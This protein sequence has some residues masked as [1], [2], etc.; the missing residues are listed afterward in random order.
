MRSK[1]AHIVVVFFII[2]TSF[3]GGVVETHPIIKIVHQ[4]GSALLVVTWLASLWLRKQPFAV[5]RMDWP[6]WGLLGGWIIAAAFGQDPRVSFEFVWATFIHII[7][8]FIAVDVIRSGH[9]RWLFEGLFLT[10]GVIVIL[11]AAE[12]LMWY[13]GIPLVGSGQGWPE[14]GGY[15]IPPVIHELSIPLNHNNPTGAYTVL[16]IPIA[17]AWS[18]TTTETDLKWGLRA[19]AA[20]LL[21]VVVF[22]QSRG[23]YLAFAALIGFSALIWI[24]R[25]DVRA[26]FPR[27]MQ[28][29]IAPRVLLTVTALIGVVAVL[30]LY[31]IIIN[32]RHP[33]VNDVTRIDLWYSAIQIF[34]DYP[35]TGAGPFQ[36]KGFRLFYGNW[37]H[38]Q[39]YLTL[40]HAHNIFFNILAE[41][42]TLLIAL[43]AW[44]IVRAGRVWRASWTRSPQATKRRLEGILV[45]VLAFS[46]HNMVDAFLQTQFV[47]PMVIFLAYVTSTDPLIAPAPSFRSN[48]YSRSKVLLGLTCILVVSGQI[49]YLPILRGALKQQRVLSLVDQ[50][51]YTE[52]L[53]TVRQAQDADP[54]LDLYVLEEATILGH[55]A[56]ESPD[57][58]LD[59][60]I[61]AYET[62][63]VLNE[64]W[65][66]G[67]HNLAALYADAGEYEHAIDAEQNAYQMYPAPTGFQFRLGQYYQLAGD[68]SA[69]RTVYLNLLKDHPWIASSGYWRDPAHPK[70]ASFLDAAI[71]Y[72]AGTISYIDLLVYTGMITSTTQRSELDFPEYLSPDIQEQLDILWPNGARTPC[73]YC[74]HVQ[75]NDLLLEAETLYHTEQ[76]TPAQADHI[77]SLARKA[78]FIDNYYSEWGWYILARLDKLDQ[79]NNEQIDLYLSQAAV[80]PV[81]RRLNFDG[82]Y[83]MQGWLTILPQARTPQMSSIAYEPWLELAER[84]IEYNNFDEVSELYELI[85]QADPYVQGLSAHIE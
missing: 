12:M 35:L 80:M 84:K 6:L 19:L 43:S 39:G 77:E 58:Y 1:I 15:T 66:A 20:G 70:R 54:W 13:F 79:H 69:A 4:L 85:Q 83:R 41:G 47:I 53:D 21:G 62:G 22:T 67:W 42:G 51:R 65:D 45:A 28:P 46:V 81:D 7:L 76:I 3:Y 29:F 52:A 55:L 59:R 25:P 18:N 72:Y 40:D 71:H 34:D 5:T 75:N 23:A 74:Y 61:Q 27:R 24:L 44:V 26:K 36:F 68:E 17:L 37:A 56:A 57:I 64:R 32:P 50:E 30:V 10:G 2:Y 9:Q 14:I 63:L 33:N 16:L 8:F 48:S 31:Q 73:L 82:I 11:G 49:L 60:A 78:I 38:S